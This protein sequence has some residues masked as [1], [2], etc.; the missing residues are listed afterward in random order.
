MGFSLFLSCFQ[1]WHTNTYIHAHLCIYTCISICTG[2]FTPVGYRRNRTDGSREYFIFSF[3]RCCQIIKDCRNFYQQCKNCASLLAMEISLIWFCLLERYKIIS[4]YFNLHPLNTNNFELFPPQ[5]YWPFKHAFYGILPNS[6]CSNFFWVIC[7]PLVHLQNLF[8]Y[9]C[10]Y[11]S[12]C[13]IHCISP[14]SI[15]CLL[16]LFCLLPYKFL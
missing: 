15:V 5:A 7:L 6:F 13:P 8:A 2:S 4:L 9:C 1:C 10:F 12:F 11:L 3:K 14:K 16:T